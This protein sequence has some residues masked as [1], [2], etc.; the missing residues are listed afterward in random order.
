[1]RN[2]IQRAIALGFVTSGV[3]ML[4]ACENESEGPLESAGEKL[5]EAA[6]NAGDTLED[7]ADD[8]SDAAEDVADDASDTAE[9][10]AEE[11]DPDGGP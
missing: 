1:M 6:E 9:D 10:V 7:T 8:V 2:K 3:L 11:L 4:G 5:D